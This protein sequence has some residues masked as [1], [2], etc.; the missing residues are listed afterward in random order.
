MNDFS[1][2]PFMLRKAWG[3][4]PTGP[5]GLSALDITKKNMIGLGSYCKALDK[6]ISKL[7]GEPT[8]KINS[9]FE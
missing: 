5:N 4:S 3:A 9:V 1:I 8:R 7:H 2:S 6:P